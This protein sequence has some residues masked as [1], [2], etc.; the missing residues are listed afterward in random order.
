MKKI[1]FQYKKALIIG[2]S[3][4]GVLVICITSLFIY[5]HHARFQVVFNQ[6]PMKTYFKNDIHSIMQI[7]GDSVTIKIPS[8]VVSTMFSE[9][10]KGLQLSEKERIQDGYINTAEGKAYMNMIIR[11]LY[12]PIAMDVD[13]ETI[14]RTIRLVFKHITLRDK[15][16]L[17]LP[18]ALENKLLDKLT[19]KASLLQV[20]LDDFH[21]PPMMGIEAV[22]PLIDQVD[23]VLK[24]NQEA[25]AKEMQDMSKARSNELYGIYQQQEDTPKR[26]ITIMD[27]TDQLT[28]AHTEEI[29]KDLLLGEQA[30]IKHLL[31][32]TDDT[33]VDKIFET[34]GRYLKRFAKEDVMNEKNKLVLGK[35]ETYCTALLDALE[36]L[37]Q[38]TYIV[39]GNYPYA[40]KDKKLLHVEDLIIKA[41]LDIPE[42]VYQK[43][44]IRFDYGKKAYRIVYEVDGTYALVGKDAYAFLDDTAYGAYAFDTPKANQVAYDTTIQEQI[45]AYFNGDVFIR[46]MNTDGQYA[47]VMASS[48]T[49]YQDYERFALE[50]SDEG[51]RIIETGISD[52]YAFSVNHS[53]FNLK[54]ITDDPVQGKIY[55]LSKDDQAVIMDQ[56]V[57]RKII[58]DKES[59][60]LIYC[61]Y[62]GKYIALKLSNGEEYVFNI[63]YAYLDKVYT[64][65]V[66]MT[67]WKDISP[68]ILL[69][70]HDQVDEEET[71]TQEQEAS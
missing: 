69:Q 36:A 25:F 23:V 54:T 18:H 57:H 42:E 50:K 12:V 66:A 22:N 21:I 53:G 51:W 15:D 40:Y 27:Q 63:K 20:S 5:L 56:L 48:T 19:T 2:A 46:Y 65:D 24:V 52:L 6:L 55:A 30:L 4:F 8:D 61:S 26:A 62:D 60:K 33:H 29:L 16:L 13:F 44:D 3:V 34:Y 7:Q 37:P 14:D 71:S 43:M 35:I 17:A 58:E 32:V 31:I 68:L 49:Y 38:E 64:K 70:D 39:F 9:R 59:V 47:F 1:N 11:G 41:Q 45:A 28:S 10:I 67:K